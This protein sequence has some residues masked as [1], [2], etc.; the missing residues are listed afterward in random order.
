MYKRQITERSTGIQYPPV[1]VENAKIIWYPKQD[2]MS[3]NTIETPAIAY[4]ENIKINGILD[5]SPLGLFV[6]G[7]IEFLNAIMNS[8][9]SQRT[10]I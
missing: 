9:E 6:N 3:I 8:K 5:Y 1:N 4:K 2:F 7:K 10:I